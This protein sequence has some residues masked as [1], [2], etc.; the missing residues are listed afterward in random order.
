MVKK[1]CWEARG[2]EVRFQIPDHC[3]RSAHDYC[4]IYYLMQI[5]YR[6]NGGTR[7]WFNSSICISLPEVGQFSS[8]LR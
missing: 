3:E 7:Q 8:V 6:E 1:L 5:Y 4:L 2:S